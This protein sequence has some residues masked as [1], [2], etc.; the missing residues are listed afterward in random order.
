MEAILK[1]I[2][3]LRE[4]VPS[5]DSY[6]Y[7]IPAIRSLGKIEMHPRVT[8]LVGENGSGKSTLLEAVAIAAGNNPEGGGKSLRFTTESSHSELARSLRLARGARRERDSYFLRAESFYNVASKIDE[9]DKDPD[10]LGPPIILSYG[11]V[12]LHKQSHGESFYSLFMNR[13]GANG[14][15]FLDEPESALSPARQLA[16]LSRLHDLCN[17]GAQFVIAT[18]SPILMGYPDAKIYAVSQSGIAPVD[19]EDTEHYRVT[20][21]FLLRRDKMLGE[22]L[23]D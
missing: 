9:L 3:L 21:D 23:R 8:Y 22:L 16:F 5:F 14:L 20:R 15:Y 7:S 4:K 10:A 17:Q 11:G 1:S 12:S 13:F 19:Y 6:P 18:H 2:E